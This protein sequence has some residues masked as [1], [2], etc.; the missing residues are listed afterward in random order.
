MKET[1]M[2]ESDIKTREVNER[3]RFGEGDAFKSI[4][5]YE[6]PFP[7]S[8]TDGEIEEITVRTC[9][10]DKD[11]PF[12]LGKDGMKDLKMVKDY[13]NFILKL[14]DKDTHINVRESQSGH[15]VMDI[16]ERDENVVGM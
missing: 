7:V 9:V 6:V 14:K 11:I 3:F 15:I 13:D 4:V 2:S 5:Q 12:L 8:K 16:P 1:H 10:V